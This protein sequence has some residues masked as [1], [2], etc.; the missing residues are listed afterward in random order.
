[1]YIY[2]YIYIHTYSVC[3]CIYIYIER[4]RDIEREVLAALLARR[5]EVL[6]GV[7]E[8]LDVGGVLG[9]HTLYFRTCV[10]FSK[11]ISMYKYVNVYIII[12]CSYNN[13]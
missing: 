1:M 7:R 5:R 13:L 12:C 10:G 2:I 9:L 8:R 4:E 11:Y 3:V 6:L